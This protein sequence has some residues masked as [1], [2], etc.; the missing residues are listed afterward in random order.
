MSA[1][2]NENTPSAT[3][4]GRTARSTFA[5]VTV[6]VWKA[7]AS[8]GRQLLDRGAKGG[9][10]GRAAAEPHHLT[11]VGLPDGRVA[12]RERGAQG[13]RRVLEAL[14]DDDVVGKH[15]DPRNPERDERA[16]LAPPD[17]GRRLLDGQ[18]EAFGSRELGVGEG[19]RL[20][21]AADPDVFLL[22]Q[23]RVDQDLVG[24]IGIRH[25]PVQDLRTRHRVHGLA[26][27]HEDDAEPIEVAL[28]ASIR[29][30]EEDAVGPRRRRH[31]RK[32]LRS[33]ANATRC[34]SCRRG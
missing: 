9:Y 10:V 15:A 32:A 7:I 31:H 12:L 11:P 13:H 21:P 34:R 22:R 8:P 26:V 14:V 17:R 6:V 25:P 19:D 27:G 5:S 29:R 4:C 28:G 18:P 2:I 33:P 20:D 23:D 16:E 24:P 1:T 30:Q 3:T